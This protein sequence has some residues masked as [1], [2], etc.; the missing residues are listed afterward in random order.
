MNVVEIAI[1]CT[2]DLDPHAGAHHTQTDKLSRNSRERIPVWCE[3]AVSA[4]F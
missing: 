3:L 1:Q 2:A 4:C